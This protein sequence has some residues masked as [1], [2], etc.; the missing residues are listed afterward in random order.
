[1]LKFFKANKLFRLSNPLKTKWNF[2]KINKNK[3]IDKKTNLIEQYNKIENYRDSNKS[4]KKV[5]NKKRKSNSKKEEDKDIYFQI[6]SSDFQLNTHI[7]KDNKSFEKFKIPEFTKINIPELLYLSQ[8]NENFFENENLVNEFIDKDILKA[9]ILNFDLKSFLYFTFKFPLFSLILLDNNINLK[10]QK[11]EKFLILKD[12]KNF[13]FYLE[14]IK[15]IAYS[16]K[17][18][19][20]QKFI[21]FIFNRTF[22][23]LVNLSYINLNKINEN[24]FAMNLNII[25]VNFIRSLDPIQQFSEKII[26]QICYTLLK[27]SSFITKYLIGEQ[28]TVIDFENTDSFNFKNFS[29]K[30]STLEESIYPYSLIKDDNRNLRIYLVYN[31]PKIFFKLY[32]KNSFVKNLELSTLFWNLILMYEYDFISQKEKKKLNYDYSLFLNILDQILEIHIR[33]NQDYSIITNMIKSLN[34]FKISLKSDIRGFQNIYIGLAKK[35]LQIK[36][37]LNEKNFVYLFIH[38][39]FMKF[40][41]KSTYNLTGSSQIFISNFFY[42]N[43]IVKNEPNKLE[44]IKTWILCNLLMA[45]GYNSFKIHENLILELEKRIPELLKNYDANKLTYLTTGMVLMKHRNDSLFK[46]ILN[47]PNFLNGELTKNFVCMAFYIAMSGYDKI[48][49]YMGFFKII[50]FNYFRLNEFDKRQVN[51]MILYLSMHKNLKENKEYFSYLMDLKNKINFMPQDLRKFSKW[52]MSVS[53]SEGLVEV[54]FKNYLEKKGIKYEYH[55]TLFNIFEVDFLIGNKIVLYLNG[56]FH[57]FIDN[58]R[59]LDVSS[60]IKE[61]YL[62][63]MG[64]YVVSVPYESCT[65]LSHKIKDDTLIYQFIKDNLPKDVFQLYFKE[66]DN[67]SN[68]KKQRD[69]GRIKPIL[70]INSKNENVKDNDLIK[71]SSNNYIKKDNKSNKKEEK[72]KINYSKEIVTSNDKLDDHPLKKIET[73]LVDPNMKKILL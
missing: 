2:C 38:F 18:S 8:L 13:R 15:V 70:S 61:N 9:D 62:R 37:L 1:M 5:E 27:K 26:L 71:K 40:T 48:E 36:D 30:R 22:E 28:E 66:K 65:F 32:Q 24:E 67:F 21:F 19:K 49:D 42:I 35:F 43:S 12:L 3:I 55:K 10:I 33:N 17:F 34:C 44:N 14:I 60:A 23:N 47:H 25:Y 4:N 46:N 73:T 39:M 59:E 50:E 16:A 54:L 31:F 64:Y 72:E 69:E 68:R 20:N 53:T 52:F 7:Y 58:N 57:Y 63:H 56:P 51:E 45:C 29:P 41:F 11:S 6:N